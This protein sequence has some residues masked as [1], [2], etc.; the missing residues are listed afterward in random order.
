MLVGFVLFIYSQFQQENEISNMENRN[1]F[2]LYC[3]QMET[4]L[5][6]ANLEAMYIALQLMADN[7]GKGHYEVSIV[8]RFY[9]TYK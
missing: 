1:C 8:C 5:I 7:E 2:S 9:V 3:I 4:Q 6:H